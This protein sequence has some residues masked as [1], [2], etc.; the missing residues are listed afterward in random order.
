MKRR[1]FVASVAASGASL[2][3]AEPGLAQTASGTATPMTETG[4]STPRSGY[5]PVNGL[6][7]Y[8]EIHGS[9]E[10]PP[11]GGGGLGGEVPVVLLQGSYMS[12]GAMEFLLSGLAETRQ[13][14]ATDFQGHGRTAD[15]DRPLTYEQMAADVAG[16]IEHLGIEQADI[17]GYSMGGAV[18]LRLAIDRPELVRKLVAISAHFRL[19]SLYPEILAGIAQVTPEIMMGTPWYEEYYAPVAPRPEDFPILVEKLKELDA[20]EF[21]WSQEID[22]IAAPTLLIYG[23]ADVIQPEYMVELFQLLGGGVPGDLT[24]LPKPRL[25]ILPS[26]TH[27]GVMNRAGWLLPMV[28][29]FL[30]EPMPEAG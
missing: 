16:L 19:D 6:Q 27:V 25:A 3:L 10:T 21:D 14:I 29:E 18:G 15:I 13:V 1:M 4:E 26:T 22:A 12:T 23:D 20:T 30:D 17:V 28:T 24:G 11:S 2:A 7:M 9:G 5:A 8:Y